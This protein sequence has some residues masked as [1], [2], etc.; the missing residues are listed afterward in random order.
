MGYYSKA[1]STESLASSSITSIMTQV[2]YPLYA[3]AQNDK[4]QLGNMIKRMTM[5]ISYITFPLLFILLLSAKPIFIL[6]YSDRWLASVPYFQVLCFA[7]MG[8]CLTAVN[9]QPIAAIG[10]SK[11]MFTWTVFKRVIGLIAV[12]GGLL[13]F[14]MK[15]LLMGVI[16]NNWFSYL[17]NILLVSKYIGYKWT[18]QFLDLAPVAVVSLVAAIVSYLCG[19]FLPFGLYLNALIE[20]IVYLIV[21]LGWSMIFKPES[22]TYA[23]SVIP[24]RFRFWEK[25]GK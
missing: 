11:I 8:A 9:T 3:E 24:I 20:I 17:V 19:R 23:L 15:G 14:G 7:G 12:V 6:L 13:L 1:M 5:T 25:R 10:L 4:K 22:F 18:R 21:Y 2:S 16:F